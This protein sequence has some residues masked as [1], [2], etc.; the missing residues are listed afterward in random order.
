MYKGNSGA[1]AQFCN[2]PYRI[3]SKRLK[4]PLAHGNVKI[5]APVPLCHPDLAK[6]CAR[7]SQR[8][9]W[10]REANRK[11]NEPRLC[12]LTKVIEGWILMVA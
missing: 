12:L 2:W 5:S 7:V 11:N 10:Q 4:Y 8:Q 9:R 1:K 6:Q 3:Q